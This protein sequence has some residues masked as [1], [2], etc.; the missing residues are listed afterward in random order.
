MKIGVS[1]YSFSQL[2]SSGAQSQK[3][4]VK[5]AKDMGFDG[6]EFTDLKPEEGLTQSQY[7][8]EIREECEKYGLPVISYTIG[9]DLLKMNG[10]DNS[11]EIER[12][13]SQLDIAKILG[14]P[15]MRHDAAWG[16]PDGMDKTSGFDGVLPV[17]IDGCKKITAYAKTL[18]IETM[19]EN[20]GTFCQRSERVEKLINGVNDPNFG[21]LI[22]IGNFACA[23]EDNAVATGNLLPYAKHI[24]AKDFHIKSGNGA[25]PGSGFFKSKGGNYLRGSIIGQ[26]N[27]PVFQCLKLI[28][29]SGYDRF[30]SVEFEGMEDCVKGISTG[31][32]N[33]KKYLEIC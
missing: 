26:G 5:L 11:E 32:E 10:S 31:L 30:L 28:K 2:I 16:I 29:N 6:I 21:A 25:D 33:L 1:S 14:V 27:V 8:E 18:G 13:C 22:D 17:L 19:V 23:D 3:S 20:H 12:V 24:H 15:T 7:A 9:A 4:V